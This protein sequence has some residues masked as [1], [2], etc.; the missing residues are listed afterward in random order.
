LTY[1]GQGG[2][3]RLA[4]LAEQIKTAWGDGPY[5][6]EIRT[7]VISSQNGEGQ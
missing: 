1:E 2:E 4:S 6:L 7:N 3:A 5:E